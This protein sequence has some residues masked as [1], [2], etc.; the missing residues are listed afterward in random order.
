MSQE[1]KWLSTKLTKLNHGIKR[2]ES[3][4]LHVKSFLTDQNLL[5]FWEGTRA[6]GITLNDEKFGMLY[7]QWVG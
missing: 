3:T 6:V 7:G 1:L 2:K 5:V 4:Y